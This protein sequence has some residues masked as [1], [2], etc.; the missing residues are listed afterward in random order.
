M[1]ILQAAILIVGGFLAGAINSIAGGGSLL[2]V[3][4]LVFTG[5][6]GTQ[7][8]G[9]NRLGVLTSS[10]TATLEF[11]RRG[12]DGLRQAAP[13]LVSVVLGSLVGASLVSQLDDATFERV[14]GF[15]MLPL[16]ILSLRKPSPKRVA[17]G[18]SW[19]RWVTVLVFFGI[20]VY[21]GAFQAGIGLI[22]VAALLQSGL[23]VVIA[24]A[25]KVIV[26]L[27]LTVVALPVFIANG[28]VA[29]PQGI[30]LAAG[31]GIG[32]VVGARL[33]IDRGDALVRPVMIAAVLASALKLL[34]VFG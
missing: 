17:E 11:R 29:W 27:V 5:V 21:G 8:N 6:P 19:S 4:L 28:D 2:S 12:V 31:F 23:D 3:P 1:T 20:G 18:E 7:A 34:G 26:T 10:I 16:L 30:A 25:V 33:T 24:N 14:F 15:L 32:G 13:I 22:L 9:S